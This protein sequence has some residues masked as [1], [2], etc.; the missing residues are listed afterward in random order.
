MDWARLHQTL[1]DPATY[2][3]RPER[4]EFRETHISRLYLAGPLV[5]KIKKPVDFGFL[6]FS[7]L[8]RRAHFCREEVRLNARFAPGTYLG[9]ATIHRGSNGRF[10]LAGQ[11]EVVEYAVVMARL[12]QVRLLPALLA[13]NAPELPAE[14]LR[15]AQR[16]ATLHDESPRADETP[17]ESVVIWKQNWEENFAQTFPL[18][19]T[20]INAEAY[21]LL[22][23][24]AA[25]FLQ[26]ETAHLLQ[27]AAAGKVREG[28]GDLHAEHICLTEPLRIY[29]CI[30]FNR[31]FRVADIVA[32]IAFLLMDLDF[33]GRP[34]LAAI[35]WQTW[36]AALGEN[37]QENRVL[38]RFAKIY[39]AC[40]RGKVDSLLALDQNA[41]AA[42]R[43]TAAA[44]ARQY[45][46]L[47]LGYLA[48]P[49]LVLTC[50]LMGVGKSVLA[51]QLAT[52]LGAVQ[53]RSDVVRKEMVGIDP[54]TAVPES[55][56]SGLYN[57]SSS[58]ATYER[59]L[60]QAKAELTA[61][62]SVVVDAS[63]VRRSDRT[64]FRAAAS[65]LGHPCLLLHLSCPPAL[66]M[67]RLHARH[68][69]GGDPSDG[70]PELI[71]AQAAAFEPPTA[72]E[73]PFT[74]DSS[75]D[76]DYNVQ[77]ILCRMISLVT[78]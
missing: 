10:N 3:H 63:F 14:M 73:D 6:D 76:V 41:A 2:P 70:R 66:T 31:R 30:E 40:V 46:N 4:V 9:V 42:T 38:L 21:A 60:E 43:A 62:H 56:G 65:D 52:A 11:G 48:P 33:R 47:A 54:L 18:I 26:T 7:T 15:L 67:L 58:V 55:F 29:D 69:H 68:T 12:P 25:S 50:G 77:A 37:P 51:R 16:L 13:R 53:L 71:A 57:A 44:R 19:G 22:Q 20:T 74:V 24:A 72:A 27:R 32:D 64:L 8:E 17:A 78:P 34:D 5:Y 28:H 36:T 1:L 45:F 75:A 61:G 23:R 59:L 39:R 35:V 49:T